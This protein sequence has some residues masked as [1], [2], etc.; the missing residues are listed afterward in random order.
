MK[1]HVEMIGLK[2]GRLTVLG[3]KGERI[4]GRHP[5]WECLCEC[6]KKCVRSAVSLKSN[7][8]P[9][10]GCSASDFQRKKND[11]TGK[12]FGKLCVIAPIKESKKGRHISWTCVCSCGNSTI[13]NGSDLRSGHTQSCGCLHQETVSKGKHGH[14]KKGTLS[15]TYVSWYSMKTRCT[16]KN[17]K[18]YLHYGARGINVCPE[19]SSF[20]KFLEDMGERP[21]G[22]S[23]DRI[24]VNGNYEPSN[25]RWADQSTQA[26]NKRKI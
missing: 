3:M 25:C 16:N 15:G 10:C 17:A 4:A 26:K 22:T 8:E 14:A 2:F 18:N 20:E 5:N 7:R 19:W 13:V 6:G 11:I 21:K 23:I 9:S 1:K 12:V 24:D